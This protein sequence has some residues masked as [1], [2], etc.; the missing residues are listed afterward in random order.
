VFSS[1]AKKEKQRRKKLASVS[2]TSKALGNIFLYQLL[3]AVY[4]KQTLIQFIIARL[5][6]QN[7]VRESTQLLAREQRDR[8]ERRRHLERYIPSIDFTD[9]EMMQYAI[10]L[11]TTAE[12]EEEQISEAITRSLSLENS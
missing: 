6:F 4:Q 7:D 12:D 10:L 11:S 5:E 3:P 1:L 9:E 2:S 8:E